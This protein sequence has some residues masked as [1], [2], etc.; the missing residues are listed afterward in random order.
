MKPETQICVIGAGLSG[1]A[2]AN[3]LL[4]E[5]R[6]VT[7]LE[8]RDRP[9]GRVFSPQGHDLGPSWIWPHNRRMQA[10]LDKLGLHRFPQYA[11]GRLVFEDAKGAIRRDLDLAT[12]GGAWRVAG[13]LAGVAEVLATRLG[14]KLR[15]SCPVHSIAQDAGGVDIT[16]DD[17]P[18]RAAHAVL[19]LPPR[20]AS[21]L[22]VSVPDVPT[23]MAGHTKLVA[24]YSTPFW[25]DQGLNGDAISHRGPLAEIHDAS[26]ADAAEGALFGFAHPGAAREPGF[27]DASLAQLARLFGA[28]AAAP[29]AVFFKDWSADPATAS[30]ADR[31]P[32]TGHPAYLPLPPDGRLIFAGTEAA[33][34]DGGFLEG[35][36]AAAEAA[37]AHI[38]AIVN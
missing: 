30:P 21:G 31:T 11:T 9:G 16:T 6:D 19:A 29:G 18:L 23:W 15:L 5:G 27:Q 10:L 28:D 4:A 20:L 33:P 1:L 25:R 37:H 8:A 17:G 24:T 34:E 14:N 35:A 22:G 7:V 12:M 26:P 3:T 13:G 32:P 36:L 38:A 2:L